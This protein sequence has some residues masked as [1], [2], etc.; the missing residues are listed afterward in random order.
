[1]F[2]HVSARFGSGDLY[3]ASDLKGVTFCA[4]AA[5]MSVYSE[6]LTWSNSDK[7][8]MTLNPEKA[9]NIIILG[10]QVT[11]LAVLNDLRILESYMAKYPGKNFFVG[12]C[13]ARRFDVTLPEGVRRLDLLRDDSQTYIQPNIVFEKPFWVKELEVT[14]SIADGML[15]RHMYPIRIGVGCNKGCTYCTIKET[16]GRGYEIP[17]GVKQIEEF[18]RSRLDVVLIAESPTAIQLTEWIG[19]AKALNK[20]ISIRNVEPVVALEIFDNIKRL[21]QLGLLRVLH[22]PIQSNNPETLK[23]MHRPVVQTQELI[24]KMKLIN[25]KQTLRATNV[26]IDYKG[27]SNPDMAKLSE[28]F[29]YISWNPFWDGKW[30]REGAEER[31]KK[32][33][34]SDFKL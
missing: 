4:C 31:H 5:C 10:C 27:F 28:S 22:C 17:I 7:S 9:D 8:Q 3:E 16:R 32:Y 20:P 25:G 2:N 15:F 33:L 30:S 24:E 18:K 19:I 13:L 1:M 21:S 6:F 26:I 23:D 34:E 14:N 11:D 29:D 12:G